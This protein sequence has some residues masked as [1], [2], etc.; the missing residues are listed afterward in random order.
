MAPRKRPLKRQRSS[1]RQSRRIRGKPPSPNHQPPSASAISTPDNRPSLVDQAKERINS[2]QP[3]D[4]QHEDELQSGLMAFL[5]HLPEDGRDSL[6][7]EIINAPSDNV[8][9]GVF[10]NLLTALAAPCK[11]IAIQIYE[12]MH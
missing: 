9:H 2:Y 1:R 4:R 7:G 11:F 3:E 12:D 8:L 5:E 6:A 10:H